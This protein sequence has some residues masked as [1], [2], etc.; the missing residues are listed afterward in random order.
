MQFATRTVLLLSIFGSALAAPSPISARANGDVTAI[1]AKREPFV[2][3]ELP[4]HHQDEHYH[5]PDDAS[6]VAPESGDTSVQPSRRPFDY[7]LNR[8]GP[9]CMKILREV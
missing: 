8:D 5:A 4:L 6:T 9:A 7:D 3:Q 2:L 1:H